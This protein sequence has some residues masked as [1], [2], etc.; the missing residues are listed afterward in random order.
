MEQVLIDGEIAAKIVA[1][2]KGYR[3]I[4]GDPGSPEVDDLHRDIDEV[5]EEL[6]G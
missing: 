2:L 1:L 5:L 3:E 6:E 4:A